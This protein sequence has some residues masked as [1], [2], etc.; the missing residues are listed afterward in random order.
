[1]VPPEQEMAVGQF[2]IEEAN[3]LETYGSMFAAFHPAAWKE[4]ETMAK[5][6]QRGL[7]FDLRPIIEE[8]GFDKVIEQMGGKEKVLEYFGLKQKTKESARKQ[9]IAEMEIETILANLTPAQRR[10][11]RRRLSEEAGSD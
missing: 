2:V 4:V 10:Q 9:P 1:V 5:T 8:M 7:Q 3:R 11:L 6:R